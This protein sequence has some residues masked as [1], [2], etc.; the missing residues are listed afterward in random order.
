MTEPK[1]RPTGA[2]VAVFLDRAEPEA[3]RRDGWTLLQLMERVT[4]SKA[5]MWGPSIV[6]F[7]RYLQ[8]DARGKATDWPLTGFSPRKANLV[9]YALG[10]PGQEAFLARLGP[11]RTGKSCLYINTLAGIDLGVLE[12]LV[13]ASAAH[14]RAHHD[15]R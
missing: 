13:A 12:S 15:T 6:G 7:G 10:F 8:T 4:G 9:V 3:R 5:E 14:T 2:D 11:H 1:T